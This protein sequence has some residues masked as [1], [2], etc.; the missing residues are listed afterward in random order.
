MV[1]ITKDNGGGDIRDDVGGW[2]WYI[3]TNDMFLGVGCSY[4][5]GWGELLPEREKEE[6][7]LNFVSH[8][9][10]SAVTGVIKWHSK[11]M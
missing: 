3:L 4:R 7:W 10:L 2:G 5:H 11:S 9:L 1:D 8:S 6:L